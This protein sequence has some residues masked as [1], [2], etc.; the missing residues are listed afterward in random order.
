[1]AV[2]EV[3][4]RPVLLLGWDA[5]REIRPAGVSSGAAVGAPQVNESTG[6][7]AISGSV[8]VGTVIVSENLVVAYPSSVV[9]SAAAGQPALTLYVTTQGI[10]G[11][12]IVGSPRLN[13][14]TAP[15]GISGSP[16]V[17]TAKVRLTVNPG[18]ITGSTSMG[19]AYV[20]NARVAFPASIEGFT[21]VGNPQVVNRR[22]V[23]RTPRNTYQWRVPPYK[24]YEGISLLKE[25]GVWSEV[26]HPDLERTLNADIYLGGGRDHLLSDGL[27]VELDAAG[28][29]SIEE[30][31]S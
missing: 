13:V 9:G 15:T 8:T 12:S 20:D 2:I 5:D 10:A 26:A 27:R 16:T 28:Y 19:E 18:T 4:A 7:A 21:P 23:F 14:K 24:E 31:V 1:M 30:I 17:G 22:F 25:N 3:T 29:P 6:P 11:T